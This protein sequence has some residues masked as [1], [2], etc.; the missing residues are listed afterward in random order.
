ML[1]KGSKVAVSGEM[2][3]RE[4]QGKTNVELKAQ[5]V[6]LLGGRPEQASERPAKAVAQNDD[7]IPF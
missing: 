3:L 2:S 1:T 6:T 5:D 4:F 7:D